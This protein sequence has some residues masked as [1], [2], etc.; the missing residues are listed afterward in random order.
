MFEYIYGYMCVLMYI[1]K[2]VCMYAY[3]CFF[4]ENY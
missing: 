3:V 2:Y 1:R 4:D